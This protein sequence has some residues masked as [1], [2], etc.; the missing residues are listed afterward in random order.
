[1]RSTRIKMLILGATVIIGSAGMG[2]QANAQFGGVV[3]CSNCSDRFAQA[4]QI[5][6]QVETALNTARQLQTQINQ[7]ND[8]LKQGVALPSTIL[9]RMTNNLRQVQDLYDQSKALSGN[10]A[11]FDTKFRQQFKSYDA[12]LAQAGRRPT[13]MADAYRRWNEQGADAMRVAMSSAGMN[14]S[15]IASEDAMLAQIVQ[16]SQS[17]SGRMQAIQAG[18]EIAAQ[19]V[20]QM[21]KLRQM[22]NSQIQSQSM[23][24]SQVME[25]QAADDAF[26]QKFRG[27]V[28]RGGVKE[29]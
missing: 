21:M 9:N 19:Q 27:T 16:R 24:Y 10:M 13:Y 15:S 4:T 29:Y 23:Y 20:Q 6:K 14:V 25:R 3:F 7:Y 1:M 17:A 28:T 8:M 12:Q 22:V 5:A 11:N 26:R 2:G 18:N